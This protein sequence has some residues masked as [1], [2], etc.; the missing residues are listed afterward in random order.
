M[1]YPWFDVT[2]DITVD[3]CKLRYARSGLGSQDESKLGTVM[4]CKHGRFSRNIFTSS[5]Y[6]SGQLF[7][8][9]QNLS[10]SCLFCLLF[11]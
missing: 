3:I 1:H 11:R 4:K 6:S 7:E 9:L 10:F 5:N 8:S 2:M